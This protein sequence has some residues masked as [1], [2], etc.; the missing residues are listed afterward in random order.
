LT[1]GL[2]DS[3]DDERDIGGRNITFNGCPPPMVSNCGPYTYGLSLAE[4]LANNYAVSNNDATPH[5]AN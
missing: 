1:G 3:F 5:R 4:L 2:R